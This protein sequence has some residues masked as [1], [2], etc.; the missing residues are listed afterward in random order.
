MKRK[1]TIMK[2]PEISDEEIRSYRDFDRLL[3][4]HQNVTAANIHLMK[5]IGF[6]VAVV[7]VGALAGFWF[8]G[9]PKAGEMDQPPQQELVFSD[10]FQFKTLPLRQDTVQSKLEVKREEGDKKSI[11]ALPSVK[12]EQKQ[13][14]ESESVVEKTEES[15]VAAQPVYI[16]AGPVDGY[17]TLYAYFSSELKYPETMMKDSIQGVVMVV[18]TINAKGEPEKITVDQSL[19]KAFDDEA[20]RLIKNMPAWKPATY[21]EKPVPSRIS[22]PITF[23]IR[24]LKSEQ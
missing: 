16:Q 13:K 9:D 7:I 8:F 3:I 17:P 19:G 14:K 18:F 1:I 4:Q 6:G 24:K 11:S 5:W 12:P 15:K 10:S 21:N 23:Q 20:V 22:L 2:K